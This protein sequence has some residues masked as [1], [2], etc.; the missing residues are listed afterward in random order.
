MSLL[1][2]ETTRPDTWT[3]E[4]ERMRDSY[5]DRRS[6]VVQ[7]EVAGMDTQQAEAV[8]NA[9][10]YS[11]DPAVTRA[12]MRVALRWAALGIVAVNIVF[13]VVLIRCL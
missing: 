12:E 11:R 10:G 6:V 9:I 3:G 1:A 8:V 2:L 7:L 4:N 13:T 5:Y